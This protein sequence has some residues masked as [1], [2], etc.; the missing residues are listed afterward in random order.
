MSAFCIL[1]C[2]LRLRL[3]GNGDSRAIDGLVCAQHQVVGVIGLLAD[4]LEELRPS[5]QRRFSLL[6]QGAV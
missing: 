5:S 4:V 6:V 3:F 1:N 2:E